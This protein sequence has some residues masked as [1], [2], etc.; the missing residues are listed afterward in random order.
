[1]LKEIGHDQAVRSDKMSTH[2]CYPQE[3]FKARKGMET[4]I[5]T[6]SQWLHL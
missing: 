3:I 4:N 1:M 2:V 5:S 6:V